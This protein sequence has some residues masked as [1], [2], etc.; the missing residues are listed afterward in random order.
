MAISFLLYTNQVHKVLVDLINEMQQE[1]HGLLG[2]KN[3][4][5]GINLSRG[6]WVL[7]ENYNYL[8]PTQLFD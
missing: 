2:K 3:E 7:P 8:N 5:R 1:T 4:S 6:N